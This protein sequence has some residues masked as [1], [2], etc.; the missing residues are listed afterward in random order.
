MYALYRHY[1]FGHEKKPKDLILMTLFSDVCFSSRTITRRIWENSEDLKIKQINQVNKLEC[2]SICLDES[3]DATD[4][5]HL[6]II[7][8][9]VFNNFDTFKE[10]LGL[11]PMNSTTT[12]RDILNAM[13]ECTNDMDIVLKKSFSHNW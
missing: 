8:R 12:G 3:T 7:I 1:Y 10:F 9:G 2:F 6:E 13:L 11:V 4:T 5:A